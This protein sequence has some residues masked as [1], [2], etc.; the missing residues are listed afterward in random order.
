M[1]LMFLAPGYCAACLADVAGFRRRSGAAF[2]LRKG[3]PA[4]IML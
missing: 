3:K 2:C 4:I 1:G